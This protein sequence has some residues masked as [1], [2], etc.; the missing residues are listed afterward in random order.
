MIYTR[1]GDKGTTS[2]VGGQRVLKCS[3]RV[4]AYGTVDELN[5]HIGML[6]EMLYEKSKS[7]ETDFDIHDNFYK[8]YEQLKKLQNRLFVVQTL[9]ATEDEATYSKLTPLD[10][11]ATSETEKL[12]DNMDGLLPKLKSF[13]IPGGSIESAQAHIARTVCRRAER[14]IV[15]LAQEEP[16][17]ESIMNFINRTS[18]YLFVLSRFILVLENKKENFWNAI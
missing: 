2:L 9:L 10:S 4:E 7:K 16:V 18:D 11:E 6:A 8:L 15:K 1:T 17:E 3:Q 5:S 12:I 13:V 14:S